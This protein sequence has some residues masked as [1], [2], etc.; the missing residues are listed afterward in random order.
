M[1]QFG[2]VLRRCRFHF[3]TTGATPYFASVSHPSRDCDSLDHTGAQGSTPW[4]PR[5]LRVIYY[6]Y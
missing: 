3:W 5:A 1:F 2:E 6:G 4:N